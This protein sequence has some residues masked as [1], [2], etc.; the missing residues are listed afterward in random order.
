[1]KRNPT[2]VY[3]VCL[4]IS[5]VLVF[6]IAISL[7]YYYRIWFDPRP[8]YFEA[9]TLD[10]LKTI[11]V[12]SPIWL[13]VAAVCGLYNRLIYIH[14]PRLY[15]RLLL[16]S[17]IGIMAL[18]SYE[19]LLG[20]EIFPTRLVALYAFVACYLLLV[21]SREVLAAGR[22]LVLRSGRGLLRMLIVG[23]N[24]SSY[25]LADYLN[26][27]TDSGYQVCGIVAQNKYIPQ[28]LMDKKFSSLKQA[29]AQT[30]PD[31]IVQTEEH[32]TEKI[33]SEAVNHHTR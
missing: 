22:R 21:I 32:D 7:A 23:D 20:A 26:G 25:I 19:F 6:I 30:T 8:F 28:Y 9:S 29:L 33:Y 27:N 17:G 15:G 24:A 4:A 10:F 14:R 13:L 2:F 1:M 31:V 11:T 3:K 12:V 16:A 18:I 5:D